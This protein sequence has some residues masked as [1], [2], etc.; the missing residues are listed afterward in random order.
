MDTLT[1]IFDK[2]IYENETGMSIG[3][4]KVIGDK[5]YVFTGTLLPTIKAKYLFYGTWTEHK[6]FG[7]QFRVESYEP[8]AS[9]EEGIIEYLSSLKGIGE[10]TA[11]KIVDLF[12]SN[13]IR[14]ME[15][16]INCL[17][18]VKGMTE[19]RFDKIKTAFE[20]VHGGRESILYLIKKGISPKLATKVYQKFTYNTMMVI[21][22]KPYQ[23]CKIPGITFPVADSLKTEITKEYE[24]SQGRFLYAAY[25]LLHEN[26]LTGSLSMP[27]IEFQKRIYSLLYKEK[28]TV[29]FIRYAIIESCK[30]E[31]LK[32]INYNGT[33]HIYIP[34]IYRIEKALAENIARFVEKEPLCNIDALIKKA[35]AEL[36][37][38]LCE[39]QINAVREAFTNKLTVI[40]GPPGTGKTT[41]LKVIA[42][43]YKLTHKDEII[44]LSPTGRAAKRMTEATGLSAYTIHSCLGIKT[45]IIYDLLPEEELTEQ[46]ESGL[47]IIDE[48]S[49][50]DSR[51]AYQ[52]FSSLG[53]NCRIVMCG[54]N[55]QL[56]S[57]QAGNVL[58]DII[59]SN[60]VPIVTLNQIFRQEKGSSIYLNLLKMRMQETNLLYDEYFCFREEN[61]MEKIQQDMVELYLEK[62]KEYGCESDVLLLSPFKKYDAGVRQL[63]EE[64]QNRLH[65]ISSEKE[66]LRFAGGSLRKGDYVMQTKNT[67]DL[68][69]G[70]TGYVENLSFKAGEKTVTVL[71]D[72][73]V[74]R[75]YKDDEI[76]ELTLAYATTVHKAQGSEA[77]CV[78]TCISDF[79]GPFLKNNIIYTACSRSKKN[80][81]IFGSKAALEK[82][83]KTE[84][85]SKR[86]TCLRLLL[87]MATGNWYTQ[88]GQIGVS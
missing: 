23:L 42:Y 83:I 70:D 53:A 22:E 65:P 66:E 88:N 76:E 86:H 15:E 1:A 57:V 45:D 12:G 7:K 74:R 9:D 46:I 43:I 2:K 20:E 84:D 31:Q 19:K 55:H 8:L 28:V 4:F 14:M 78:I 18:K 6:K 52:L 79:H 44:C 34:G 68:V 29:D 49:M 62:I 80:V 35:E 40:V 36:G 75:T 25:Y 48:C 26:E 21:K 24:L 39:G 81:T 47:V 54:D 69:N 73:G 87:V 64:I 85:T 11:K 71:F 10:K 60:A 58:Y 30:R 72:T 5:C 56:P 50:L 59:E 61:S 82:A 63:N 41:L 16:D 51:V 27:I 32:C 3:L 37:I 13:T 33:Q 77:Q 38:T 17:L 67:Q